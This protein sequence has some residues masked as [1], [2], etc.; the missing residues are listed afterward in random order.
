M[1]CLRL[2]DYREEFLNP[3]NRRKK[4]AINSATHNETK[5]TFKV[6]VKKVVEI[7]GKRG[8]KTKIKKEIKS[9][10]LFSN[11]FF[12]LWF[13]LRINKKGLLA[14]FSIFILIFSTPVIDNH[15]QYSN[16]FDYRQKK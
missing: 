7:I 5:N 3:H 8:S 6:E 9:Q 14:N 15:Y 10:N 4:R 2:Q 1:F 13:I 11:N 16:Y 12:T